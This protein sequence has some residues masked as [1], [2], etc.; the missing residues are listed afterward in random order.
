ML[1]RAKVPTC[2]VS[3]P[4]KLNNFANGTY[5]PNGPGG[6]CRSARSRRRWARQPKP[7]CRC[8]GRRFGSPV[9]SMPI[10]PAMMYESCRARDVRQGRAQMQVGDPERAPAT[11]AR[12][13]GRASRRLRRCGRTLSAASECSVLSEIV[14]RPVAHENREYSPAPASAPCD[15]GSAPGFIQLAGMQCDRRGQ[16][17]GQQQLAPRIRNQERRS[18]CGVHQRDLEGNSVHSGD[19]CDA[20]E[21]NVVDLR[22]A[23]Q[24][25][26]KSGDV[27]SRQLH[28]DPEERRED[29]RAQAESVAARGDQRQQQSEQPVIQAEVEREGDQQQQRTWARR[30]RRRRASRDRPSSS[31][32]DTR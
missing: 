16:C 1:P 5:S 17:R 24:V 27:G 14:E 13:S 10:E 4:A 11:P 30:G 23:Q 21:R 8:S 3:P 22:G 32:R 2:C 20:R 7:S 15:V 6:S 19:G 25:P 26:G 28:R 18:H 12:R 31:C 29:Q 9:C